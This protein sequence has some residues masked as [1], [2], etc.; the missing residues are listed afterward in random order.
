MIEPT[1][2]SIVFGSD[3]NDGI[4]DVW[5]S[6]KLMKFYHKFSNAYCKLPIRISFCQLN[7]SYITVLKFKLHYERKQSIIDEMYVLIQVWCTLGKDFVHS[8]HIC[9]HEIN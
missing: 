5:T 7:S 3:S 2:N 4:L 8:S 1:L 9:T 6:I